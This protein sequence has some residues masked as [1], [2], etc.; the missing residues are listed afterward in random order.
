MIRIVLNNLTGIA[1]LCSDSV[2][3]NIVDPNAVNLREGKWLT[4]SSKPQNINVKCRE[5]TNGKRVKSPKDILS[6]G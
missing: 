2:E 3:N 5:K 6:L 4:T 1:K